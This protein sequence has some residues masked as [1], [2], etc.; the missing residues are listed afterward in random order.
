VAFERDGQPI[1]KAEEYDFSRTGQIVCEI[2][3]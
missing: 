3:P 2:A 1:S